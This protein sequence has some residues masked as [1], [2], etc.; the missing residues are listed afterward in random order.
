MNPLKAPR[1]DGM[2]GLFF[3]NYWGFMGSQFVEAVQSFFRE[4]W[5]LKEL[6][7]TYIT[8]IPKG[9]GSL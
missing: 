6:N 8:Q 7:Q 4:G 1:P 5:M 2:P 3:K 9:A